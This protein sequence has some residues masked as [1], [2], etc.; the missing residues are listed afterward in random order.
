[1]KFFDCNVSLGC[2]KKIEEI[3]E[4]M[5]EYHV[6]YCGL[7]SLYSE[8]YHPVD[9]NNDLNSLCFQYSNIR[10]VFTAIT[11]SGD[12]FPKEEDFL[13]F[14]K[15]S[16]GIG[17]YF[18]P[19]DDSLIRSMCIW[20]MKKYYEVLSECK[21]PLFIKSEKI[22]LHVI[23]D[24]LQSFPDLKIVLLDIHYSL[25][26]ELFALM[27]AVKNLYLETSGLKGYKMISKISNK[28]GANRM[29]FG[30]RFPVFEP[31]TSIA[32]IIYSDISEEEK[33]IIA[34]NPIFGELL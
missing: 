8:T 9:G 33:Q 28:Y 17:I 4:Y 22:S 23:Y 25:A 26:R 15:K 12:D 16:K 13:T 6:D 7:R 19:Y 24:I 11:T 30:S 1:M 2:M 20:S 14:V 18:S 3:D 27:E 29:V 10:P 5:Q 31:G 34:F 21:I 32:D